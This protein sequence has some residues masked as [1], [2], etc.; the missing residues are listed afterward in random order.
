MSKV[1]TYS[2][3][4]NIA[5]RRKEYAAAAAEINNLIVPPSYPD[6]QFDFGRDGFV[7]LDPKT[8]KAVQTNGTRAQ[9]DLHC[10]WCN[11]HEIRC[12]R[13]AIYEVQPLV[14]P[15]FENA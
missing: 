12:G 1:F 3:P 11:D 6:S 5:I 9:A 2:R 15:V 8:R 7:I 14:R 4:G 10:R 13:T